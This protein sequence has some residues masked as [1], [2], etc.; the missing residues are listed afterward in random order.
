LRR[1]KR[2]GGVFVISIAVLAGL[3]SILALAAASQRAATATQIKRMEARTARILA[4]AGLQRA[5]TELQDQPVSPTTVND[6]W[7][8]L[9]QI[10][11]EAFEL[12]RGTFRV[13]IVDAAGKVNLNSA[14]QGQLELLPL[15]TEQVDAILDW[16]E[17]SRQ[18]RPGGAK[19]EYYNQ[20]FNAYNTRLGT[21]QSVNELLLVKNFTARDLY[22]VREDI[23]DTNRPV[24]T[25]TGEQVQ[26][27]L[28][29]MVTVDSTSQAVDANGTA[30]L[31]VN[32][33]T[34]QQ[35]V[36]RAQLSLQVAT[37]IVQ[38]RP[39]TGYTD[40]GQVLDTPGLNIQSARTLLNTCTAG[41]QN[42]AGK[43][44]LNTATE[45]ILLTIPNLPPDAAN[46]I[47]TRQS[48]GFSE[49][50]ELLDVPGMN[51]LALLQQT[52]GYFE[53]NSQTFL[54][55]VL[56]ESGG[57]QIAI[58]A[59]VSVTDGTPKLVRIEEPP[60]A[61]VLTIWGWEPEPV[62]TTTLKGVQ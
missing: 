2:A 40:I 51:N 1:T 20:L 48:S 34:A 58:Q 53:V 22:T 15:T 24:R 5:L 23:V 55:R 25:S 3:V 21:F 19:D 54:V 49:L 35:L 33:A 37:Q 18:P 28:D 62:A 47:V 26:L 38:R 16:R 8:L 45:E 12:G 60:Y 50:G 59:T 13:Q 14:T 56:G 11:G 29:E 32:Q 4:E 46:A 44:N 17:E 31:N 10:G 27:P 30:K 41:G 42:Q 61:D 57:T 52:A 9:G 6:D 39:G 7:A 43:I 36:Q